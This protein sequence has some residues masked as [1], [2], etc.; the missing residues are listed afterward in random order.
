VSIRTEPASDEIAAVRIAGMLSEA[1][2]CILLVRSDLEFRSPEGVLLRRLLLHLLDEM[3]W[4]DSTLTLGLRVDG[5]VW[6]VD[7]NARI[8]RLRM[9]VQ[10]WKLGPIPAELREATEQGI[11][12]PLSIS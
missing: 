4:L 1:M 11:G 3:D 2:N 5:I 9:A 7:M 8:A 10:R 12:V 6:P